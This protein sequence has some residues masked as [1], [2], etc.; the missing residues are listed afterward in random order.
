MKTIKTFVILLMITPLLTT[1][2]F[3]KADRSFGDFY[4]KYAET[5]GFITFSIPA[6]L[7]GFFVDKEEADFHDLLSQVKQIRFMIYD[8]EDHKPA[9][10]NAYLK[11]LKQSIPASGYEDLMII[12]DGCDEVRFKIRE[13]RKTINELLMVITAEES[14]VVMSIK[15][16]LD[17][18]QMKKLSES[19]DIQK[20]KQSNRQ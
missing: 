16:S 3:A 9:R 1:Q 19:I 20:V 2:V 10:R 12:K 14:F 7:V 6:S 13:N 8:G 11:E 17:Q 18:K 15:G 4:H 5:D